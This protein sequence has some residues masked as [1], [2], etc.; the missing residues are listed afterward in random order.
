MSESNGARFRILSA[1]LLTTVQDLGRFGFQRYGMPVCGAMDSLALRLA[2][3][4]VGNRDD[5]AGLEMTIKG[6]RIAFETDAVIAVTGAD[7]SPMVNQE[8][9]PL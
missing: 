4:V 2:N 3:R 7:L 1:G 9:I 5:A 8:P 6:P